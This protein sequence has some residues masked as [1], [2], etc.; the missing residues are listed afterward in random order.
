MVEKVFRGFIE[1]SYAKL[2]RL[3]GKRTIQDEKISWTVTIKDKEYI[4]YDFIPFEMSQFTH[5]WRV[6]SEFKDLSDLEELIQN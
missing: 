6:E 5:K 4:I 1:T 2:T 3:F